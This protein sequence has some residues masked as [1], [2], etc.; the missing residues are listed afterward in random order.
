[1]VRVPQLGRHPELLARHQ[2]IGKRAAEAVAH[3][4]LV[5]VVARA[6]KVTVAQGDGVVDSLR[7]R[8]AR[9]LPEA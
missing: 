4:R 9:D 1:M 6:V 5:A 7:R 2:R 3:L 8:C